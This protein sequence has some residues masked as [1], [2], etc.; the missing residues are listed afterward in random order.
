MGNSCIISL[1][2]IPYIKFTALEF[3]YFEVS[4]HATFVSLCC[5]TSAGWLVARPPPY[6]QTFDEN[7]QSVIVAFRGRGGLPCL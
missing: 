5:V 7:L 3:Q 1:S 2:I 4:L 6:S